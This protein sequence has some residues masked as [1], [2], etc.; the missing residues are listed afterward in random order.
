[1]TD[2]TQRSDKQL[3]Y[4]L[5]QKMDKM[6]SKIG[7]GDIECAGKHIAWA[8]AA[9]SVG[10]DWTDGLDYKRP[11][12]TYEHKYGDF[13]GADYIR[14]WEAFRSKFERDDIKPEEIYG[15]RL[16]LV[17]GSA[18]IDWADARYEL[19]EGRLANAWSNIVKVRDAIGAERFN[20]VMLLTK[21]AVIGDHEYYVQCM[22]D[23]VVNV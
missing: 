21:Y 17:D 5:N 16:H 14:D 9:L 13:R 22:L 7:D 10:L 11:W 20:Q 15:D 4:N 23:E 12:A 3:A 18:F 19:E 2:Y 1:M 6:Y 8:A